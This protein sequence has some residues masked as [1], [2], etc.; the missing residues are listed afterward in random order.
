[1]HILF[2]SLLISFSFFGHQVSNCQLLLWIAPVILQIADEVSSGSGDIYCV[3][4][5]VFIAA[6]VIS[7]GSWELCS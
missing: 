7:G 2:I 4:M 5:Y 6:V 1:M 3:C